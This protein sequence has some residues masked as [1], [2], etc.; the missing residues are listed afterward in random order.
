MENLVVREKEI[1]DSIE[2]LKDDLDAIQQNRSN[3][4]IKNFV[5][6]Q[7]MTPG[8]QRMQCVLELQIKM[9][10]I[11]SSQLDSDKISIEI[12]QLEKGGER[13]GDY[14]ERFRQIDIEKKKLEL[15]QIDLARIG[16][17]REAECLYSILQSLPKFTREQY[18]EEEQLYWTMR[19][20]EQLELS[21]LNDR[22]NLQAINQINRGIL[23]EPLSQ[24]Q[25]MA[26]TR[27]LMGLI[28]EKVAPEWN[29]NGGKKGG[30]NVRP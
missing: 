7:H 23:S 11:R 15:A 14:E 10:N 29:H 4:Q 17:V 30:R 13:Y 20:N 28:E 26:G 18:E 22:G 8:R 3:F 21:A 1:L 25:I 9:F 2:N 5:V 6:G 12:E 16:Q 24:E 19:L 27:S